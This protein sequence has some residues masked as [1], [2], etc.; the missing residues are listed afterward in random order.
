M[1]I[2]ILT[3]CSPSG[4]GIY[5]YTLSLVEALKQYSIKHEYL[6]IR[7]PDF[8]KIL[9]K[10]IIIDR[11]KCSTWLKIKRL[12]HI[13]TGMAIGNLVPNLTED[14]SNIELI[15]SPVISFLPYHLKKPYIVTIHDFQ[16]KYYPQFFTLKQRIGRG[17]IY[18]TAKKALVVVCESKFVK[19]D[20]IKFLD[21]P[22][23]KIKIIPSPP[24]GYILT[25]KIYEEKLSEIKAKYSLPDRFLYYPAQFWYHKN[26]IKL[27][28]SIYLIRKSKKENIY[29][30]LS[31]AKQNNFKNVMK[32]IEELGLNKY[33][34]YLGYVPFED[35][36][37]IFKLSTGLVMPTLF[38]SVS[39]PIWEAFY[40]GVPVI[41][42]NVCALPEQV[43]DAGLLFDPNDIEDMADKI[44]RIWIDESLRKELIQK[45]YERVKN[46]TFEN[47]AKQWEKVIEEALAK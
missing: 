42:S 30:I 44:Y 25:H 37:Y 33:V 28:E 23:N 3:I 7:Y 21:I 4:G 18:K 34:K 13:Y 1:N 29:L 16:H 40:L 41:S 8:P 19:M 46:L 39:M 15:I 17:I 32:K 10:D 27:L 36:P 31:G 38:E 14:L 35:I 26:H 12:I 47:Y 9:D 20:L 43:G 11:K 5:Q 2:G 24:P 22:E 45:G 6:Q